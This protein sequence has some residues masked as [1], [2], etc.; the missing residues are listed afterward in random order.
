M[1]F[2]STTENTAKVPQ[3]KASAK[4][5]QSATTFIAMAPLQL[6]LVRYENPVGY[7]P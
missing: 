1:A 3:N 5:G 2:E 4:A 6:F 7:T